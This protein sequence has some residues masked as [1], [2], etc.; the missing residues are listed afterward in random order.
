MH[1]SGHATGLSCSLVNLEGLEVYHQF[2]T[3][4]GNST[5]YF[6]WELKSYSS[7]R[8][9]A[10]DHANLHN[11][12]KLQ[13]SQLKWDLG[14]AYYWVLLPI[15]GFITPLRGRISFHWA[16]SIELVFVGLNGTN[17]VGTSAHKNIFSV[18][19][20]TRRKDGTFPDEMCKSC[21][22]IEYQDF[23]TAEKVSKI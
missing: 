14:D 17:H 23:S 12:K 15:L 18:N 21:G 16:M 9:S 1:V 2:K 10:C 11:P 7:V 8:Y 6:S 20:A 5:L 13:S 4:W 22:T 3:E 19:S